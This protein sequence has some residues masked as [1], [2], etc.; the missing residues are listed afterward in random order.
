MKKKIIV[1]ICAAVPVAA[2]AAIFYRRCH[3]KYSVQ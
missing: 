3:R 1:T 2:L